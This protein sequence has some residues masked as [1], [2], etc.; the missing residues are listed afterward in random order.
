MLNS[1]FHTAIDSIQTGKKFV[2]TN[3]VKYEPLADMLTTYVDAQT[4][5][6]KSFIDTSLKSAMDFGDML[7]NKDFTKEVI[8]AY[9]PTQMKAASRK[10]K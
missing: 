7:M 10:A 3:T 1:L 6:T 4:Q 2:V 8:E 5:Y 9:T